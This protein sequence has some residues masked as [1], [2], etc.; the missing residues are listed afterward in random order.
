MALD[1]KKVEYFNTIVEGHVGDGSV[2]LS[3][4]A[5]VGISWYAFKA[6]PVER[7]RTRFSLFPNDSE[8]MVDAAKK[9]GV[10]LDGPHPAMLIKGGDEAGALAD[11]YKKLA[12]ADIFVKEATGIADINN[13]YGVVLYFKSEECE[14]A[15]A[16]LERY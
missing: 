6:V 3:V 2:M 7:G 14:K 9:A 12:L 5:N 11:I 8:K 16:V 1:I 10:D 4:F 15:H 13:G